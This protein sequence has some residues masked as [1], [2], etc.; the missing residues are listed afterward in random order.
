MIPTSIEVSSATAG[1][2]LQELLIF[3]YAAK[4]QLKARP[5]PIVQTHAVSA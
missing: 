1:P 2:N 5:K 4:E 3:I